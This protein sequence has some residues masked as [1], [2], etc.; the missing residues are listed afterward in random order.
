MV[1]ENAHH[2][3][4]AGDDHDVHVALKDD[5]VLRNNFTKDGHQA[6]LGSRQFGGIFSNFID[7]ADNI[8]SLL[9]KIVTLAIQNF[10]EA[11]HRLAQRYIPP[12]PASELLCHGHGLR[13]EPLYLARARNDQLVILAQFVN[14]QDGDDVLQIFVT[15]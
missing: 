10:T 6:S 1:G 8:E 3:F 2:A 7:R 15:L 11:R 5:S 14:A 9:R 4:T 12:W 13:E